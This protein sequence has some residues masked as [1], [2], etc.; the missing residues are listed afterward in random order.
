MNQSID[1]SFED[2]DLG[3]IWAQAEKWCKTAV[4]HCSRRPVKDVWEVIAPVQP[5]SLQEFED[6][7]YEARWWKP[8]PMMD[9]ELLLRTDGIDPIGKPYE[10][11]DLSGGIGVRFT[12]DL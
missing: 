12:A 4:K 3:C 10:P 8:V 9:I 7:V 5:D 6:G 11:D 2:T 1:S